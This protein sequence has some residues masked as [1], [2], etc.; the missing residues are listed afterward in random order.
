MPGIEM[1]EDGRVFTCCLVL[2]DQFTTIIGNALDRKS[3]SPTVSQKIRLRKLLFELNFPIFSTK[4]A[5][6][7]RTLY[8]YR[9]SIKVSQR[10]F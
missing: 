5:E 2:T 10:P 1:G 4:T 3:V 8:S 6:Q 9:N 7:N